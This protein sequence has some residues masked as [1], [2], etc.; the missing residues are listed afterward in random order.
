MELLALTE[1]TQPAQPYAGVRRPH[2]Q[3]PLL[4]CP[5]PSF[6]L[7]RTVTALV[8]VD[9]LSGIQVHAMLEKARKE[10][11]QQKQ[12]QLAARV[13]DEQTE[14]QPEPVLP[15]LTEALDLSVNKK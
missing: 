12:Q 8:P 10:K 3:S 11:K 15:D 6:S 9:I 5:P 13:S 14:Q 1:S 7:G 4:P 2:H